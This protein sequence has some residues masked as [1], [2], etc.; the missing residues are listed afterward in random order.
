MTAYWHRYS[1]LDGSTHHE[2]C[3]LPSNV[4]CGLESPIFY[5]RGICGILIEDAK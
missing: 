2:S 4:T 3:M 1:S 5:T